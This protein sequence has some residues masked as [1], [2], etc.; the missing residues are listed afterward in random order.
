MPSPY[1]AEPQHGNV[2]GIADIL[3]NLIRGKVAL[4]VLEMRFDPVHRRRIRL[5][6]GRERVGRER[7]GRERVGRERVARER[8]RDRGRVK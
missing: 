3:G 7:V 5:R 1:L 2:R 6:V 8:V 4:H